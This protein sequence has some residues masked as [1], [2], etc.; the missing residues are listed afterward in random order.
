METKYE[1]AKQQ[2]MFIV[3]YCEATSRHYYD[4]TYKGLCYDCP[5]RNRYT[6]CCDC[7]TVTQVGLRTY[8]KENNPIFYNLLDEKVVQEEYNIVLNHLKFTSL[9]KP[10]Q[11]EIKYKIKIKRKN[12]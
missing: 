8:E 11:N 9:K 2:A 3:G 12:K 6:G 5:F 10:E 4:T 7:K 1:T